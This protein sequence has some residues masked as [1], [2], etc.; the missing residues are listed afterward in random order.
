MHA[1]GQQHHEH[2]TIGI[3]PDR[4]AGESCVTVCAL[5]QVFARAVITIC[6]IPPESAMTRG[7]P[8]E[9]RDCR[10]RDDLNAVV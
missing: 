5:S 3:D 8:G 6:S 10:I 7:A 4:S 1:I 9:K 2:L